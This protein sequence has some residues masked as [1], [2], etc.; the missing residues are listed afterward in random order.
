MRLLPL[1]LEKPASREARSLRRRG[2]AA[3]LAVCVSALLTSCFPF[4]APLENRGFITVN[5]DHD[6][7][8]VW[9]GANTAWNSLSGVYM[10]ATSTHGEIF[11]EAK[12]EFVASQDSPLNLGEL[13]SSMVVSHSERIPLSTADGLTVGI[14]TR[15]GQSVKALSTLDFEFEKGMLEDWP[16]GMWLQS[17]GGLRSA[18]CR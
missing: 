3:V 16:R 1:N 2:A 6:V 7:L 13:P 15:V 18:A 14:S 17:G 12:G 10:T 9:C 4:G 11:L 5:E 8:L